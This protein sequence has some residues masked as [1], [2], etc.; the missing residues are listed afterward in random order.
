MI[1]WRTRGKRWIT[2]LLIGITAMT[3]VV[4]VGAASSSVSDTTLSNA[5]QEKEELQTALQEAQNLISNLKNSQDD[6]ETK[7]Q[8]LDTKMSSISTQ[9][10]DMEQKLD[11]KNT[12]ISDTEALLEQSEKN[13][14]KQYEDMKLRIQY[15]YE[16]SSS[17]SCLELLCASGS[18]SEFLNAADYVYQLSEYDR[19]MLEQY[20]EATKLIA[21]TKAQLEQD[22]TDLE[23]M[24]SQLQDQKS[25]VAAL[26][27]QKETELAGL[28]SELS[29]A[30][31]TAQTY[32]NEIAAQEEVINE[33]AVQLA[34]QKQREEEKKLAAQKKAEEEAAKAA[35]ATETPDS[36]QTSTETKEE[37]SSET[38]EAP[39][40]S[41]GAFTWPC[42]S[43]T[44]V[45]SDYG[46]RIS[47]T[48][49]ASSYH[50]GIDIGASEGS[51]IV[52]AAEGEVIYSGYSAAAGN[53]VIISHG[54]GLCT[55]YMHASSLLVSEGDMVSAGDAIA[56]V[57]STGVS[58]GSHLHFG[59]SL[60]GAYVSPWDYL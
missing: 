12:E 16:N 9:I 19:S 48:A 46:S 6:I 3:S 21:D 10:S 30:E 41:G 33:I 31:G 35:A 2:F 13:A 44:R 40:Y 25:A 42:P 26:K 18:I 28:G 34:L 14:A 50:K 11:T 52:A 1:N 45:T 17:L 49:G 53:H 47:P 43:S 15:M 27:G 60:N 29:T 59:V 4:E 36:G 37:Q 8:E 5:Q 7:I 51:S 39:T 54:N 55:V 23:T 22:Y 32:E 56:K 38:A 58:T 24:Q 20:Q 57:G